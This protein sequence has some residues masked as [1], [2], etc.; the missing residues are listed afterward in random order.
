[1]YFLGKA[2]DIRNTDC[3]VCRSDRDAV[4]F[5]DHLHEAV[6][7]IDGGYELWQGTRKI[8]A[9]RATD[10]DRQCLDYLGITERMQASLIG[11]EEILER[12]RTS[13]AR[14]ERL[15][16]R[17]AKLRETYSTMASSRADEVTS[18]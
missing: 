14:S 1:M 2:G 16:N 17:L 9:A 11:R 3:F 10:N 5:A 8:V 15:L 12:S 4:V 18:P 7:D 6:C 13:F